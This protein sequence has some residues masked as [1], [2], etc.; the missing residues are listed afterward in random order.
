MILKDIPK[1][2]R[3]NN[4]VDFQYKNINYQCSIKYLPF[5]NDERKLEHEEAEED[6]KDLLTPVF[7]VEWRTECGTLYK[8][9]WLMSGAI[10]WFFESYEKEI[11]LENFAL[12][13]REVHNFLERVTEL[14]K[15]NSEKEVQ[16]TQL[17]LF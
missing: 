3:K 10:L 5:S 4:I 11:S 8:S 9:Q 14:H 7:H 16:Q 2:F 17:S 1:E 6:L 15:K 13:S 12:E